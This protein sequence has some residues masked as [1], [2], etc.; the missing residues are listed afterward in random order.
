MD[1][2]SCKKHLLKNS[3]LGS[4]TGQTWLQISQHRSVDVVHDG[5]SPLDYNSHQCIIQGRKEGKSNHYLSK[6]WTMSQL[7]YNCAV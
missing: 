5:A 6:Y 3:V 1:Y 7:F 4:E 2:Q